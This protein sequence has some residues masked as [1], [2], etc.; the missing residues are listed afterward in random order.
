MKPLIKTIISVVVMLVLAGL[1]IYY[2]RNHLSDFNQISLINPL[3]LIPL[4][5]LF[6]LSYFFIGLQTKVLLEPLGVK[7]KHLE[8]YMLSIVT[9]FYNI[10]TPAHGGMGIR[11][12]Y[13]KKKHNFTYTNFLASLAGMYV[14]TFFIG[15]LFGLISLFLIYEIYRIFNWIVFFIFLGLFIP[16]LLIIIFSPEFKESKNKFLNKFIH[17]ANGWNIIKKDKKVIWKCLFFTL[18]MLLISTTTQILSYH[19]FGINLHFIQGLFLA[20]IGSITIL[21]QL[22]PGN[23]GVSETVAVFS[24]LI[25]GITPAT[26]LSVA[27]LGRIVQML[28]MFTLGPIFSVILLK[29]PKENVSKN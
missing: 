9:G 7:L 3:W 2:I 26:S 21:I 27:I 17:V 28:T 10:I 5:A 6:L 19:I 4:I 16:L 14:L 12:V 25:L 11:A 15:S 29:K 20:T 23:L 24:A 1:L 8:V 13:L 18:I 22:T